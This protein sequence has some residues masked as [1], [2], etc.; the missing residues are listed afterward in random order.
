[1][2][3]YFRLSALASHMGTS[4]EHEISCEKMNRQQEWHKQCRLVA[5]VTEGDDAGWVF[6]KTVYVQY[7]HK[8]V[9]SVGFVPAWFP[10]TVIT[11]EEYF[12]RK[13]EDHYSVR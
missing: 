6:F 2:K 7:E 3:E 12:K 5:R 9:M 13:L 4:V 1:M 8:F 11:A 10:W